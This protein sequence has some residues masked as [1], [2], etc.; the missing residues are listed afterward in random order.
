MEKRKKFLLGA[1]I[2]L[3]AAAGCTTF[4]LLPEKPLKLY[5]QIDAR[6]TSLAFEVSGKIASVHAIEGD[7]VQAGDVL[8]RLDDADFAI[9]LAQAQSARDVA[10]S[11]LKLLEAGTRAEEIEMA[12]AS[13]AAAKAR[14]GHSLRECVR[15]K[16]LG[17]ATSAS[18]R[19]T[20]CAQADV[21]K[22]QALEAQKELEVALAGP[23]AE[24]L[25]VRRASLALAETDVR[26]AQHRMKQT[27]LVAPF[28][29]IVRARLTEPGDTAG[30]SI[31]SFEL[32]PASM[33][34]AKV[35]IDEIN[36]GKI[37]QGDR[38]RVRVDSFP[39]KAFTGQIG[40]ISPVAEFTP[41]SVQTEAI[42]TSLVY[43]VRITLEE[44]GD[45]LR[46]GMP[47]TVELGK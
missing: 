8:A 4:V 36:L 46:R 44:G 33:P 10:S 6:V 47:V 26:L 39:D 11:E 14:Q 2:A 7:T 38:V 37:R 23:R 13:L 19:D 29:G 31:P 28:A 20:A 1:A 35:W 16:K 18:K 27:M 12:R 42:R 25:T 43:E 24:E 40:F 3:A 32:A 5:G 34:W 15:E 9:N 45:L 17:S 22:A 41:R 30:P 21:A